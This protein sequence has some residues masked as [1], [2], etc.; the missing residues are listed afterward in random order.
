LTEQYV[1]QELR[2]SLGQT[3][4]YW[5]AEHATAE[6]DFVFQYQAGIYPVEVKAEENLKAK[7]LKVY[8]DKYTP[9]VAIRTSMSDYRHDDWLLNLPLY[10]ISQIFAE[11]EK[12]I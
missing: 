8:S 12:F 7:S 11:C 9:A 10:G 5:S 4:C 2:C 3:P 1:A 6:V